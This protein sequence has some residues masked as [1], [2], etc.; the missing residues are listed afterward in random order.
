MK[1]FSLALILILAASSLLAQKPGAQ[2]SDKDIR[3]DLSSEK[4]G[5]EPT[6]FL[7][8]VGNWV[9][10]EDEGK[11]V[12]M[13][14]GRQWEKGTPAGGLAEKARAIYGSRHEEF[15]DNVKAFAYF[16]YAVANS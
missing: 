13:V 10:V 7:S 14:D 6:K 4:A 16:P 2:K 5:T 8:V 9:I 11:K 3:I 12:L 15:L 1:S